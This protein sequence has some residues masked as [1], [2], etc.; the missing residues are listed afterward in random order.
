MRLLKHALRASPAL[1]EPRTTQWVLVFEDD[2]Q[3][4]P[5]PA[6]DPD[7]IARA[8]AV[9]REAIARANVLGVN[10]VFFGWFFWSDNHIGKTTRIAPQIWRVDGAPVRTHA[11]AL[12]GAI[13]PA[14]LHM[15]RRRRCYVPMDVLLRQTLPSSLLVT[16]SPHV[17]RIRN[18]RG[19]DALFG[20]AGLGS[21]TR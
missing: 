2:A 9:M 13:A 20:Q 6:L 11:Y 16:R 18:S 10:A 3:L 17:H 21:D 4:L 5:A 1:A 15:L 8:S 19:G 12:R 14:V 7:A